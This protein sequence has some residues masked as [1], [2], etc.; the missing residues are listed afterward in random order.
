[1]S[2]LEGELYIDP[3]GPSPQRRAALAWDELAEVFLPVDAD[4]WPD[5]V[6]LIEQEIAPWLRAAQLADFTT[7]LS[8]KTFS[9]EAAAENARRRSTATRTPSTM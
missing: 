4:A 1:M 6:A 3:V 7:Q 2:A 5:P 9:A 8:A